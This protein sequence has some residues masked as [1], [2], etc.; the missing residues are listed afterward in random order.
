MDSLVTVVIPEVDHTT[1]RTHADVSMLVRTRETNGLIFYLGT[2][3]DDIS[4]CKDISLRYFSAWVCDIIE[5]LALS[6][7]DSVFVF[8][9]KIVS[10]ISE[11]LMCF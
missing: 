1:Y 11:K 3:E 10:D 5:F 7:S 4:I 2:R 6:L 8:H 9:R